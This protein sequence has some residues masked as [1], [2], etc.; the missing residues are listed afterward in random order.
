MAGLG[1]EVVGRPL[2]AALAPPEQA[3]AAGV[4][5]RPAAADA[6]AP[7]PGTAPT[8]EHAG[9]AAF[10][11]ARGLPQDAAL[12]L[13]ERV[14]QLHGP[15]LSHAT[16]AVA[17]GNWLS[18]EALPP[19]ARRA[20]P[21]LQR[22]PAAK[23]SGGSWRS[24]LAAGTVH[25]DLREQGQLDLLRRFGPLS[26][27]TRVWTDDQPD[28]LVETAEALD[29]LPRVNYQLAAW[30]LDRLRPLLADAGLHGA[31]LVPRRSRARR[32]RS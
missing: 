30:E 16:V 6:F 17:A 27:D 26:T 32:V 28:P 22:L 2:A 21:E 3:A 19:D 14:L 10:S 13:F 31:V 24:R 23:R 15:R 5:R 25:L 12:A 20:A 9:R 8:Q 7:G 1:A 18:R 4:D 11:P 29:D